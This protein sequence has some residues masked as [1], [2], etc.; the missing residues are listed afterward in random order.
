MKSQLHIF[1][2]VTCLAQYWSHSAQQTLATKIML[3]FSKT[4]NKTLTPKQE[5]FSNIKHS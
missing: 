5:Q 3:H 1:M 2:Y 4:S